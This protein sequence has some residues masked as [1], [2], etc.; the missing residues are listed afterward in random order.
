MAIPRT[1]GFPCHWWSDYIDLGFD[2]LGF[3]A[4]LWGNE[5]R[6]IEGI[7]RLPLG[8]ITE[9]TKLPMATIKRHITTLEQADLIEYDPKAGVVFLHQYMD[10]QKQLNQTKVPPS[11]ATGIARN[12]ATLRLRC[13]GILNSWENDRDKHPRLVEALEEEYH[14]EYND[15]G[16]ND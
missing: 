14:T 12:I 10:C 9:D 8:Y 2:T 16:S 11:T 3:L 7:Y 1:S 4:Y 15:S 6:R 5:R 13:N